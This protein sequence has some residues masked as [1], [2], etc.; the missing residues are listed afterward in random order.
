MTGRITLPTRPVA[1]CL[2]VLAAATLSLLGGL[3]F[4]R[5]FAGGHSGVLAGVPSAGPAHQGLDSLPADAA[6]PVSGALGAS[7][8]AYVVRTAGGEL[9]AVN[10]A[11]HMPMRF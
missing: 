4:T 3:A 8:R 6:G 2:T 1:V 11:Q 7:N 9:R 5:L 10:P